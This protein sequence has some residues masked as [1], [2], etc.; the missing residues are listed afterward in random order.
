MDIQA[1][2][3]RAGML[4]KWK[5][6]LYSVFKTEHRTPGKGRGFVQVKLRSHAKGSVV[7]YKFA[8]DDFVE[9]ISLTPKEM[10][11]LYEEGDQLWFMDNES[12]EQTSISKEELGDQ[13]NYLIPNTNVLVQW[14]DEKPFSIDLPAS[15]EL[16]V[17][18][19]EPAIKGATV[20][21]V[22]KPAKTETGLVVQVPGFIKEGEKIK[23]STADGAYQG[24]AN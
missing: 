9:R 21:N 11:Y 14:Y 22:T 10:Q 20:T 19:T 5:D 1:T 8:S 12:Y 13:I 15:L 18:E 23:V 17:I 6:E 16:E 4:V 7:D 2:Q 24:R 3:L